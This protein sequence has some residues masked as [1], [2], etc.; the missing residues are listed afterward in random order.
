M[1]AYAKR[2]IEFEEIIYAD[3]GPDYDIFGFV[4]HQKSKVE[5]TYLKKLMLYE[6]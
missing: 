6:D 3:Y 4:Y 2:N 1:V 5:S